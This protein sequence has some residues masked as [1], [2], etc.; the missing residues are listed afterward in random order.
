MSIDRKLGSKH[1]I[2]RTPKSLYT[3]LLKTIIPELFKNMI[4][5]P[6]ILHSAQLKMLSE[7]DF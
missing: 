6:D 1:S 3:A 5:A 7:N 4:K 2:I